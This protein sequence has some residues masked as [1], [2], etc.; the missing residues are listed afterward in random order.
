MAGLSSQFGDTAAFDAFYSTLA[1]EKKDEFLRVG[2]L[3]LFLVKQ[4]NWHVDVP[5]TDPVIDY[6][7]NSFKLVSLFSLVESLG[8]EEHQDFYEW[9]GEVAD[10]IYPIDDKA[11]LARL[12]ERYKATFGSI[13]R[14]TRFFERLPPQRQV[15]LCESITFDGA[16]AKSVKHVAQF[17]YNLRSKFVHEGEFVLDI[18][19]VPVFSRHKKSNTL[20]SLTM[21]EL[22]ATFEE[23][24]V[25]HFRHAA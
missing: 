10:E 18:A 9:L 13:R 24:V 20:T 4:G 12:H 6:L 17:L 16:P 14:C 15:R 22:L 19:S 8:A 11:A 2:S 3:Y 25:A 5:D 23:G 7:T 21:P 1:D